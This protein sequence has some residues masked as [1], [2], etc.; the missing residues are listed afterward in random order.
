MKQTKK[1]MKAFVYLLNPDFLFN[2]IADAI[3]KKKKFD[4][5]ELN[6]GLIIR[7]PLI[8]AENIEVNRIESWSIT[9][10]MVF[11]LVEIKLV[12][13]EEKI[14]TDYYNDLI[15]ILFDVAE[16]KYVGEK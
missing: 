8:G 14:W 15:T 9:R 2:K 16:D 13:D 12:G 3:F 4:S 11:D 7:N 1:L 5:Y 10:E 6:E